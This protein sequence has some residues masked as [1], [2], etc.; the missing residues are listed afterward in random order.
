MSFKHAALNSCCVCRGRVL[1]TKRA[2]H[3]LLRFFKEATKFEKKGLALI[4]DFYFVLDCFCFPYGPYIKA[5][6]LT[7]EY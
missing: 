7:L 4:I 1:H 6:I 5:S 3:K 2:I